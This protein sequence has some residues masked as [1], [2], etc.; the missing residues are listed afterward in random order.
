MRLHRRCRG[1]DGSQQRP[2]NG[3]FATQALMGLQRL[4]QRLAIVV[5][6]NAWTA[7][8]FLRGLLSFARVSPTL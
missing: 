6:S 1:K 3:G 4:R 8:P 7:A 2:V 5:N